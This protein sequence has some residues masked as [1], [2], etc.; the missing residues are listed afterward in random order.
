MTKVNLLTQ[1]EYA[2][3]RGC[4]AV[5][6][7]K[8][9]KAGRISTID[10]KID[11]IVADIQWAANTRARQPNRD[12]DAGDLLS[13]A[14]DPAGASASAGASQPPD[15]SADPS[16]A[17]PTDTSYATARARRERAEAEEAEIRTAKIKGELVSRDDIERA[18]FEI[19]RELRDRLM[20]SGK[21]LAAEVAPL[22]TAQA[23]EVAIDREHRIVLE[24]LVKGIR[25]R[26]GLRDVP[27]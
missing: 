23:C 16:T 10:G 13:Q 4:S 20:S 7:H 11:P 8:A 22:A 9:V 21:R 3:H 15:A 24:L 25:E 27:A 17:V 5:A 26:A 14:A 12:R 19:S 2:V 1:S 18:L 6:V